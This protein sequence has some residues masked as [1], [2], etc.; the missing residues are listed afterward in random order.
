MATYHNILIFFLT[1]VTSGMFYLMSSNRSLLT[2][3]SVLLIMRVYALYYRNRWILFIVTLEFTAG[4]ILACVSS[5]V[6]EQ[7][8]QCFDFASGLL[9][10]WLE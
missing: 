6:D 5:T 10:C 2:C 3:V 4:S 1:F 8:Y 9:N 7:K